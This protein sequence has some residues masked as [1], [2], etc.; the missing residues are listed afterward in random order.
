MLR[1]WFYWWLGL[2]ILFANKVRYRFTGYRRPREFSVDDT[3]R[4]VKYDHAVVE[5]WERVL[6]E[7]GFGSQPFVGKRI[8]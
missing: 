8:L 7:K 1:Q 6:V 5:R 3:R 4:A 2:G